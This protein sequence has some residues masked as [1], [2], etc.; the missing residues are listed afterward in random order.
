MKITP[1]HKDIIH[2]KMILNDLRRLDMDFGVEVNR[3]HFNIK[4]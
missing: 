3:S 2:A 4:R 1:Y